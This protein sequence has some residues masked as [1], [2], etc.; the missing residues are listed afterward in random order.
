MRATLGTMT[1]ATQKMNDQ[2]A[3]NTKDV[4][5]SIYSGSLSSIVMPEARNALTRKAVKF[6][7]ENMNAYTDILRTNLPL[8]TSSR[9]N[10]MD[11]LANALALYQE[12]P[13]RRSDIVDLESA[14]RELSSTVS[15]SISGL[16]GLRSAVYGL[17]RIMSDLNKAKRGLL[18]QLD[19]LISECDSIIK[20]SENI[21]HSIQAMT[22]A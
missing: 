17:P 19:L 6:V 4:G 10:A 5:E 1:T 8:L 13:G 18:G 22:P 11:A 20:T 21:I 9:T 14:L 7:S 15:V 16:G 2:I 3:S 12:M